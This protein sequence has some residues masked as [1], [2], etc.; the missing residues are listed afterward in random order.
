MKV[1]IAGSRT[2]H[3]YEFLKQKMKELNLKNE[4]SRNYN[5]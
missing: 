5:G 1:I 3:D 4:K 2:F